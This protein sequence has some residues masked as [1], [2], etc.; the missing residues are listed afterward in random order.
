MEHAG[1]LLRGSRVSVMGR[2]EMGGR[3]VFDFLGPAMDARDH[4]YHSSSSSMCAASSSGS[5]PQ[6]PGCNYRTCYIP[7][8][9]VRNSL[10]PCAVGL[11]CLLPCSGVLDALATSESE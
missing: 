1:N 7:R 2:V 3:C 8:A 4:T 11:V 9:W 5:A 10:L 6:L